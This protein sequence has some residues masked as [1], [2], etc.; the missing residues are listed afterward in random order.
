MRTSSACC[1]RWLVAIFT[2]ALVSLSAAPSPILGQTTTGSVRGYVRDPSG[3][4][5]AEAQVSARDLSM[6][7]SRNTLT[8]A[9]GFYN[10]AGLRPGQ[11]EITIRRIGFSPQTRTVQVLIGQTRD[12]DVALA[13]TATTLQTVV[14]TAATVQETRTSE[15]GTNVSREQIENLPNFERNFLDFTKL[16]PGMTAQSPTSTDKVFAAG[17]QP[18]EA[19]NVFVDGATYKNDVLRGGVAGQDASKGN[20]FPQG[21]VQEFRVITQNYK[22]EYQKAASAIITA[23][24]R[25]GGNQWEGDLFAYGVGKSYVAKDAFA[26]REG[27]SRP[28]YKR[29]QA[30]GSAGGPLAKDRLFFFGTYELNFRDEPQYVTLGSNAALAPS[31]LNPQQYTGQFASQFREHLGF[32]KVTWAQSE[33][34]TVDVSG[35]LRHET[36]FRDFGGQRAFEAATNLKID[37]INGVANWKYAGDRWL[38]EAQLNGQHFTWNP[39]PA[40]PTL[41]AKDYDRIVRIGGQDSW[42][43][44]TQNRVSLRDDITRSGLRAAGDHVFKGGVSVDFLSYDADKRQQDPPIYRFRT[45]EAYAFPFQAAFGFGNSKVSTNN[46]QLGLYVQDDWSVTQKLLLNLGLRWDVETNMINNDYVTPQAIRDSLTGPLR[47]RFLVDRR[48]LRADGTCCDIVKV[49]VIGQLGGFDRFF[50]SGRSDR[51]TFLGAW[52]PRLGASYD[53]FGD[54]RTVL[55]GGAGVYY[56]RTYWNALFDERFRRQYHVLTVNF[57]STTC[58][59]CIPW[60]NRYFDPAQLR[61]LAGTA[62]VDELFLVANDLKPPKTYQLSAGA[63]Q[64]V[65]TMQLTLSYNAVRGFDGFNYVKATNFG[66]LNPTYSQAFVTDDRVKTWYDAMQFQIERPLR[67]RSR[68]GGSLAYTFARSEEQGQIDS[69]FWDFDDR[70]PTVADMPRQ[71]APGNQAH[72]VTANA[73]IRAP[74]DFLV[75]TIISLGSGITSN[76]VDQTNGAGYGLERNYVFTP[77][78]RP[79]LGIGHVFNTQTADIRLQK[80]FAVANG[81]RVGLVIDLFNA[82]NSANFSCYNTTIGDANLNKPGCGG[83]GRR[84]QVGLRYGLRPLS[85]GDA[86][87]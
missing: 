45:A 7:I 8:N 68:W 58:P 2:A 77:P 1:R 87:R 5:I 27:L 21:A 76:A 31:G 36:D 71:R 34:S 47:S 32:A 25:S 82:L 78:G 44:F 20:P 81:Q 50:T 9:G 60:D 28:D 15:V 65:G 43:K 74:Y 79:F 6:G 49:D 69:F 23:T 39:N 35:T 18:P 59:T 53:L 62:G 83:L 57:Q 66:G 14:V 84:L 37:V 10:M 24:T 12:L 61:T 63:R 70:H 30:G 42:Q 17:A 29:L 38:N 19:V 41:I 26:A 13:Q 80:D 56:D 73:V 51:P 54:G 46:T 52:Q 16:A 22:A 40:N 67:Q 11:Y 4:P 86:A 33:R 55:F 3:V 72:T 75:S 85:S 48:V 64:G